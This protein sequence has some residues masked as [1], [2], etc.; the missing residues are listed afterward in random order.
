[1]VGRVV[2]WPGPVRAGPVGVAL[3]SRR[4]WCGCPG[5]RAVERPGS[6]QLVVVFAGAVVEVGE[7]VRDDV[8]QR[9]GTALC[10]WTGLGRTVEGIGTGIERVEPDPHDRSRRRVERTTHVDATVEAMLEVQPLRRLQTRLARLLV[11]QHTPVRHEPLEVADPSQLGGLFRAAPARHTLASPPRRVGIGL[12]PPVPRPCPRRP[13]R[14]GT[15]GLG[16]RKRELGR[17]PVALGGEIGKPVELDV[18]GD[19]H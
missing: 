17:Q 19:E 4:L 7:G 1:M 15:L 8:A 2:W 9:V 11:D 10:Q 16:D 12:Q 13:P 18:G 14:P 3:T 5:A 6:A